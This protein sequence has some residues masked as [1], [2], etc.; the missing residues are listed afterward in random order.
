M[1]TQL[2][3]D[4]LLEINKK[5]TAV[6]SNPKNTLARRL[7]QAQHPTEIGV[8]KCMDGRLHLPVMTNTALG[9]IRP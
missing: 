8:F 2:G 4:K 9:I 5:H 3:I 7:Y 1:Q 6:Y